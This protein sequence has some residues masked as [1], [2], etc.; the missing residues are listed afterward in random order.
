MAPEHNS[1]ESLSSDKLKSLWGLL[2]GERAFHFNAFL[3]TAPTSS[4]FTALAKRF[5]KPEV[6]NAI[7]DLDGTLVPPYAEICKDV[8]ELLRGYIDNGQEVAI[9]TNSPDA[10]RLNPLRDEGVKI[11]DTGISKPSLEGFSR[12]CDQCHIDPAE[13]A[14]IGNFA[15]TD[16]PLVP[17]GSAPFFPMNI[18]VESIPPQWNLV[19]S[20]RKYFR[21]RLFHT[22]NKAS[23]GIV[24]VRNPMVLL[25]V[26]R[27]YY[28]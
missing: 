11:A 13:T 22:L 24:L 1:K 10:D 9:Y 2:A 20:L 21:A 14:M 17:E 18:L 4:E 25:D 5:G 12:L 23:A 28:M 19:P 8:R 26:N 3:H 15:V 27:N 7:F 16:M 6:R